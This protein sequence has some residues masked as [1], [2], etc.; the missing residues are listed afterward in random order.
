MFTHLWV[1]SGPMNQTRV[2]RFSDCFEIG[3]VEH[4]HLVCL[5]GRQ[6]VPGL[7]TFRHPNQSMVGIGEPVRSCQLRMR[8]RFDEAAAKVTT[9]LTMNGPNAVSCFGG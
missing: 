7:R 8:R 9:T 3:E 6:V 5:V 2:T 1:K 4:A